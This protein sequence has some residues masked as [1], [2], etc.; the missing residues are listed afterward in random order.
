MNVL[1][2]STWSLLLVTAAFGV[3]LNFWPALPSPD[4]FDEVVDPASSQVW[5]IPPAPKSAAELRIA[6]LEGR[7]EVLERAMEI[8]IPP[9]S[10]NPWHNPYPAN[11]CE[12][13]PDTDGP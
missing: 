2:A 7:I 12:Q 1:L 6:D 3:A 11:L 8:L 4:N 13:K 9:C 5:R 10:D